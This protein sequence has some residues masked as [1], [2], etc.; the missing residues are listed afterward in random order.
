MENATDAEIQAMPT[1]LDI[2]EALT[3]G[4][5]REP[6]ADALIKLVR[7]GDAPVDDAQFVTDIQQQILAQDTEAG[8][9]ELVDT[10]TA[11]LG[12]NGKITQGSLEKIISLAES[13]KAKTPEV[14]EIKRFEKAI[15]KKI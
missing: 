9:N 3:F 5:I 14:E 6:A 15:I 7:G 2:T 10:A 8:I 1:E 13:T 11:A 12:P 4:E